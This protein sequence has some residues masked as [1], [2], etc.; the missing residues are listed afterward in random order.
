MSDYVP[1]RPGFRTRCNEDL[2][3][4]ELPGQVRGARKLQQ[5][6]GLAVLLKHPEQSVLARG[7][8]TKLRP[9]GV[10]P[11]GALWEEAQRSPGGLTWE[12]GQGTQFPH[13][14]LE[15][16]PFGVS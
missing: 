16:I 10:L 12:G 8:R 6:G 4:A 14:S 11:E 9:S 5:P 1:G 3:K 7:P 15:K 2:L 13:L